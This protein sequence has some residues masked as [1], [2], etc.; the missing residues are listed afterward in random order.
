VLGVAGPLLEGFGRAL[1]PGGELVLVGGN[2][3]HGLVAGW[4]DGR[5][6]AEPAGFLGL[7]QR[8]APAEAG[9]LAARLAE[10]AAPARV[11][12]AYPGLWLREDVYAF[13]GHYGDLHTTTPTFERLAAGAE[14]AAEALEQRPGDPQHVPLRTVAQLD[15]IAEDH[16]PVGAGRPREQRLAHGGPP[17]DVRARGR[18][19]ME[20]GDDERPHAR[21]G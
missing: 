14:R 17:Q 12:M 2:H 5:L 8:F 13:H 4:L 20:V 19:E 18:A 21:P 9:P 10:R 11:T 3:G 15:G 1:G 6:L 7:E 16:Q